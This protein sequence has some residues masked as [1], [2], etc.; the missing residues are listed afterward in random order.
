MKE[1]LHIIKIGGNIIDN[2]KKLDKFLNDF[3]KIKEPKILIHGGG[4]IA[5]D[6]AEKMGIKQ[7]MIDGRRITDAETLK[8]ISMVYGGFISK[9]IVAKLH[10]NGDSA[11][12][13]SG[14]DFNSILST[15]R[16]D[17]PVDFGF[18]GDICKVNIDTLNKIL[19]I[20]LV[21]VFCAITHDG[22]GQL[23]NTNADSI[24]NS[25]ASEMSEKYNCFL[26]YCFEKKGVLEKIED[27]NSVI[28]EIT[29]KYYETLKQNGKISQGMIP[30]LDNAF[31]A[32]Q[33]GVKTVYIMSA[34][35][36]YS[37]FLTKKH[38]GTK[39]SE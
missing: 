28:S 6:I 30:K 22:K 15:K 2:S 3:S 19:N 21:P 9:N 12:G 38:H 4:K 13:L 7:K 18:V 14:A 37:S 1:N 24:A 29:P 8:V 23:L 20:G 35:D 33:K 36:I 26:Y 34:E 17:K 5:T 27:E 31:S 16:S 39:I 10:A 11:L 25:I 32:I